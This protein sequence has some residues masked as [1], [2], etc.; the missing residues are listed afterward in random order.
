MHKKFKSLFSIKKLAFTLAETLIVMGVIGVVAALTLPN[1]NQSTNNKEK[2]AK[3]KKIYTNLND[4]LGRAVAVYG[5]VNEW[6]VKD[7]NNNQTRTKRF[8]ERMTEFMKLTKVC[9]IG[10]GN[11]CFVQNDATYWDGTGRPDSPYNWDW[12]Y[13]VVTADGT[14]VHFE[15][16]SENNIAISVDIDG[17]KGKYA[18]GVDLF[19]FDINNGGNELTPTGIS[20]TDDQLKTKCFNPNN[21]DSGGCTGWVIQNENMD[22]LKCASS[23]SWSKTTCK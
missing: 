3:V 19:K 18:W 1:L 16:N 21:S 2:V 20:Y 8:A 14:S 7:D 15:Y 10:T 22:Y 11:G 5:P 9:G 12:G 23:L 4:A 13:S 6:F 17:Q